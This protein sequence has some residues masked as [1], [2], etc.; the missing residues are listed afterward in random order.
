[1]SG[2][3]NYQC[4]PEMHRGRRVKRPRRERNLQPKTTTKGA[5]RDNRHTHLA[6]IRALIRRKLTKF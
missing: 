5:E 1:L 3:N 6:S 2:A 4:A